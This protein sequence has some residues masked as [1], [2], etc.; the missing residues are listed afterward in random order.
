M[1][2]DWSIENSIFDILFT[3]L[4]HLSHHV[5]SFE[6]PIEGKVLVGLAEG[7]SDARVSGVIQGGPPQLV[8]PG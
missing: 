2:V 5:T 7:S 3:A 6:D 4:P 1:E 8:E